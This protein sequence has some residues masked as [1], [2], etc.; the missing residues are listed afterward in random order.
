MRHGMEFGR[1]CPRCWLGK[2]VG[3]LECGRTMSGME[4]WVGE[5]DRREQV[6]EKVI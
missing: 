5:S 6:R 1:I 2:G 4:F 3:C